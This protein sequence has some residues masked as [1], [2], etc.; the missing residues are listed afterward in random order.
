M[1]YYTGVPQVLPVVEVLRHGGLPAADS[2]AGPPREEG[3]EVPP[4]CH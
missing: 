1:M 4:E 2:V 3:A